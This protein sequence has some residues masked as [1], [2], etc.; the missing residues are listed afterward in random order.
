MYNMLVYYFWE[1][2]EDLSE[3]EEGLCYLNL[4]FFI[5]LF[6][7]DEIVFYFFYEIK[8]LFL[9]CLSKLD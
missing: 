7:E 9:D 6:I 2:V 4:L 8:V 1:S 5:F 3:L